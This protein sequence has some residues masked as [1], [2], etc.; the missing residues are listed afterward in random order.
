MGGIGWEGLG[1]L[2]RRLGGLERGE[3]QGLLES[4]VY[5]AFLFVGTPTQRKTMGYHPSGG[6]GTEQ[7]HTQGVYLQP[8][9]APRS[10]THPMTE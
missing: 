3:A 9:Q 7:A 10:H 1:V 4:G 8:L 6:Q 2:G 5:R